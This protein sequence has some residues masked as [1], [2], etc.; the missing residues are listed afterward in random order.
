MFM[1]CMQAEGE[2]IEVG[3]IT[4]IYTQLWF[5]GQDYYGNNHYNYNISW[6]T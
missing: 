3:L 5:A 2:S 4:I 6:Q 1:D